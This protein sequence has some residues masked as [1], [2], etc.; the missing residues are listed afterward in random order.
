MYLSVFAIPHVSFGCGSQTD[1][2]VD[3]TGLSELVPSF[4]PAAFSTGCAALARRAAAACF[5][6]LDRGPHDQAVLEAQIH[7]G[8][9]RRTLEDLG[10]QL[11][12]HHQA[13]RHVARAGQDGERQ[14]AEIDAIVVVPDHFDPQHGQAPLRHR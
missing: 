4:S 3:C 7:L 10:A 13:A 6:R 11:L 14:T 9:D 5:D 2:L 1:R 12:E 8:Q